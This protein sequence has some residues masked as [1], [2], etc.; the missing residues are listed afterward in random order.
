MGEREEGAS[1][2]EYRRRALEAV[3][4]IAMAA[5]KAYDEAPE[6]D[7]EGYDEGFV[8]WHEDWQKKA[9]DPFSVPQLNT[10]LTRDCEAQFLSEVPPGVQ[11]YYLCRHKDCMFVCRS[12]DWTHNA[13]Q[14]P[15]R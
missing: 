8:L 1:R 15:P 3:L 2:N 5:S 6:K 7:Q 12:T 10:V 13:P 4:I 9:E 11:E 14:Q